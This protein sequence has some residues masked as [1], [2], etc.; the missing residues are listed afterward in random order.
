M[1]DKTIQ[2]GTDSITVKTSQLTEHPLSF[3]IRGEHASGAFHE[4][5]LTIGDADLQ[6]VASV[7]DAQ[8][9]LDEARQH[10]ATM[11]SKKAAI[12][13]LAAKLQ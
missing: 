10:A 13:A 5:T 6:N 9:W 1:Q 4:E 2:V 12:S 7:A 8:K 11:C 3:K